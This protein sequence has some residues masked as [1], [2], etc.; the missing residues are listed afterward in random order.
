LDL[1]YL[2]CLDEVI[3]CAPESFALP[4]WGN[5]NEK[6]PPGLVIITKSGG[7]NNPAQGLFTLNNLKNI[8]KIHGV[9]R[10]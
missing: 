1:G 6:Q 3:F 10:I 7:E 5:G 8:S 4:P 2:T 9:Y